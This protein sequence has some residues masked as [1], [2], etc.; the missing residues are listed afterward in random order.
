MMRLLLTTYVVL[1]ALWAVP[2]VAQ[3][4]APAAPA[5]VE[6]PAEP[7]PPPPVAVEPQRLPER[8]EI[9]L[10]KETVEITS[11]FSGEALTIFGAVDNADPLIQRQGRYDIFLILEGPTADL[12]ARRKGR[13][14]GVW[15]TV[16]NQPF[17][18]LPL[19]YLIASTRLPQDITNL[20]ALAR[21][22]LGVGQIRIQPDRDKPQ[23]PQLDEF[24]AQV[25]A[26]KERTGLYAEFTSGVRFVSQSLFRAELRLPTNVPL[27]NHRARAYL[28]RSGELVAQTEAPLRIA[29]AG[30]EF[31]ISAFARNQSLAYGLLS[32]LAAF[33]IGW[34]G[35]I[36]FRRD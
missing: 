24:I 10:S 21:L 20:N 9:G 25:R 19:S 11:N 31:Q 3:E 8:I 22:S 14:F 35:R 6:A 32:V 15:M 30:L 18:N 4:S 5:A 36:L 16:E 2:A 27:G 17:D 29:K 33:V 1:G 28:F 23:S 34:L 12:V 13:V 7:L 26:L